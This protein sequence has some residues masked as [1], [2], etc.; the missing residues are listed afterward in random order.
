MAL[1]E[2]RRLARRP[3]AT[4]RYELHQPTAAEIPPI[5]VFFEEQPYA[6]ARRTKA[7][8]SCRW[9]ACRDPDAIEN[10][11]VYVCAK[12]RDRR[13]LMEAM[14]EKAGARG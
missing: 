6:S 12:F 1:Y 7:S 11:T 4:A 5:R 2:N 3:Q 13:G 10:A 9:T 8:A 14:T